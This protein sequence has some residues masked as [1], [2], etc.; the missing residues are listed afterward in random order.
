MC[1]FGRELCVNV[2]L[3][4]QYTCIDAILSDLTYVQNTG[5]VK[6]YIL[7]KLKI[8]IPTDFSWIFVSFRIY[9]PRD[10]FNII[11]INV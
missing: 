2:Q 11:W 7:F 3:Y 5:F 4:A 10:F 8:I 6:Q 1:H 9:N